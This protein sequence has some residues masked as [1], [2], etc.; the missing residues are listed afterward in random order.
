VAPTAKENYYERVYQREFQQVFSVLRDVSG[1]YPCGWFLPQQGAILNN[2]D[3]L[4][5]TP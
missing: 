3:L 1:W 4:G 2:N 5:D